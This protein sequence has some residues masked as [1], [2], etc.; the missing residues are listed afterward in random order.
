MLRPARPLAPPRGI[1]TVLILL[2]VGLSLS[3]AVLGTA[4]YIRSHQQQDVAAHAQTQAQMK[5][6]TGAE[7]VRQYL[8]QLQDSGQLA[9]LYAKAPPFD[10]TLSG[11][12]VTSAVLASIT[13]TDST[14]KT[15]TARI[16]GVT[17]PDSSAEARAVLEVVYAAS[18][19]PSTA[20]PRP[21]VLTYRRNLRLGGSIRVVARDANDQTPYEINVIGDIDTEG[22]SIDNVDALFSTGSIHIGSGSSFKTLHANCDVKLTGSVTATHIKARRNVCATGSA[23]TGSAGDIMANGSVDTQASH[24]RNGILHARVQ[25]EGVQS[26]RAPGFTPSGSSTEA[27]TCAL[28]TVNGVN[29]SNGGAGAQRAVT[30]GDVRIMGGGRLLDLQA[31]GNLIVD[32]GGAHASGTIGGSVTGSSPLGSGSITRTASFTVNPPPPLVPLVSIET[33]TFN[34]YDAEASA[35]Y[36]FKIDAAG[37]RKVTVQNVDGMADGDYYLGNYSGGGYKD[38]LCSAVSGGPDSPNCT[39]PARTAT[40]TICK[41]FSEWNECFSYSTSTGWQVNGLSMAPGV[42]WFEGDLELGNGTYF[43]TFIATGNI[44]TAGGHKTYAPNYA[45]YGGQLD[46]VTYAPQGICANSDFPALKPRQFCSADMYTPLDIGNY[47]FMAGSRT[48]ADWDDTTG[49][50]GGNI[51]IG[52]SA[53]IF[54][55][56]KAGNEFQSGGSTTIH[57]YASALALGE[58]VANSLG[59][60]TTFDLRNLPPTFTP[61]G[62]ASP[63]PGGT[64]AAGGPVHM[65]WS[66]YL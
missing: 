46:G 20:P 15:V 37:Y 12:G 59:G 39:A 41:G 30:K 48:N 27:P 6:W 7:L 54:G 44:R 38:Y 51:T 47:A 8:Q 36:V 42:A 10:L 33:E 24:E 14:A 62:Q 1:A 52:A 13:A 11:D 21:S 4:H 35:N 9:A 19:S 66:R 25:P 2:L 17:A 64:P 60:S 53:E 61:G 29:F 45:G 63:N 58:R 50:R 28:P 18:A 3:A 23:G 55:N 43:N 40:K 57:G 16:T 31:E 49:Y 34:A 26:C 5:A 56:V 65:R 32:G 22:N